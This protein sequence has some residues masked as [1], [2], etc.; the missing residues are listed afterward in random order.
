MYI[1]CLRSFLYY[2]PSRPVSFYIYIFILNL[3][4]GAYSHYDCRLYTLSVLSPT[5]QDH[6]K[7]QHCM[8]LYDSRSFLPF[9]TASYSLHAPYSLD[10]FTANSNSGNTFGWAAEKMQENTALQGYCAIRC[11]NIAKLAISL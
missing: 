6:L 10:S 11:N 7:H 2:Y 1:S 4:S 9:H 3:H 5:Q 8:L